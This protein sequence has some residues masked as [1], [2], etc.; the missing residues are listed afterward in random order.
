MSGVVTFTRKLVITLAA[1][2]APSPLVACGGDDASGGSDHAGSGGA[3]AGTGGA[4]TGTGAGGAGTGT[5]GAGTGTGGTSSGGPITPLNPHTMAL[6][7]YLY[8]TIEDG[9][10]GC[11]GFA[12]AVL[13]QGE[14]PDESSCLSQPLPL[15]LGTTKKAVSVAVG[16]DHGCALFEDGSVKCWGDNAWGQ[17]GLDDVEARGDEPGELGEALPFVNLG[18]PAVAIAASLGRSCALLQSGVVKCWG[19]SLDGGMNYGDSAGEMAALAPLTFEPEGTTVVD[20]AMGRAS[21]CFLL[22]SGK[23]NCRGANYTSQLL[24]DSTPEHNADLGATRTATDVASADA[25][26]CALLDGNRVKCWG[27]NMSCQTG[28][29]LDAFE[30]GDDVEERGDALVELDLGADFVPVTIVGG[31]EH[32]CALSAEGVVK[33]WGANGRDQLGYERANGTSD[34]CAPTEDGVTPP[35]WPLE[36]KVVELAAGGFGTCA[37]F[38]NGEVECTMTPLGC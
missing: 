26:H 17:L 9:V 24:E 33:C 32:F 12:G 4:G 18:E 7:D 38:E 22:S 30:V 37:R 6:A 14:G 3:V 10:V 29:A 34:V 21:S 11:W 13:G 27:D 19:D 15:D 2:G 5:G 36:A 1:L 23:V 8:C 35:A 16:D 20:L 31:E 28:Y 25:A